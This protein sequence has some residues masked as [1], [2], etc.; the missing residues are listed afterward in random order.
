MHLLQVRFILTDEDIRTSNAKLVFE[1]GS[2][3]RAGVIYDSENELMSI[4]KDGVWVDDDLLEDGTS[5]L[6]S[7]GPSDPISFGRFNDEKSL[8][9]ADLDLDEVYIWE[10]AVDPELLQRRFNHPI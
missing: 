10:K 9:Q 5:W 1:I 2:W 3:F 7:T 8:M 4:Y 6:S